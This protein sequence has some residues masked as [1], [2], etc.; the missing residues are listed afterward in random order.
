MLEE[1]NQR[2]KAR[3]SSTEPSVIPQP[4]VSDPRGSF[5]L[6][7]GDASENSSIANENDGS[8]SMRPSTNENLAV[9]FE[10]TYHGTTSTLFDA[11]SE[12]PKRT[13]AENAVTKMRSASSMQNN[14][15]AAATRQR[16]CLCA[17]MRRITDL[18][19]QASWRESIFRLANWILTV[20]ILN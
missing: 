11:G 6:D 18:L 16:L 7:D 1:E 4:G 8:G 9:D 2:L 3:L 13:A 20:L 19:P 14:L 5:G 17:T 10:E 15:I 12:P